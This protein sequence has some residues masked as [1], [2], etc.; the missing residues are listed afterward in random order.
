M[1]SE[2]TRIK[3]AAD[4]LGYHP[5]TLRRKLAANEFPRDLITTVTGKPR[6]KRSA[7]KKYI[8]SGHEPKQNAADIAHRLVPK[9]FVSQLEDRQLF[10]PFTIRE[11]L[12][13]HW[14]RQI[15]CQGGQLDAGGIEDA[16]VECAARGMRIISE[17]KTLQSYY[18][19]KEGYKP[20]D[21]HVDVVLRRLDC[22]RPSMYVIECY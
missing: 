1:E 20:N 4:M 19:E 12:S 15:A 14:L 21:V 13:D 11:V 7:L 8:N 5:R 18:H 16:F 17:E 6:L 22:A 9:I 10:T 2:V 3:E